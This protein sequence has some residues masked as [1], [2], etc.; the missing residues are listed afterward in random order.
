M[1][2][3]NKLKILPLVGMA[4]LLTGCWDNVE[5]NERHVIL[6]LAID[7][8]LSFNEKM[9]INKQKA[10]KLTYCIPDMKKLSGQESLGDEVKSNITIEAAS[11]AASIDEIE[12]KTQDTVTFSHTKALILGEEILKDR[13]LFQ[14]TI[15]TLTRDMAIS[16]NTMI[17]ATHGEAGEL[18]K[19][20]NPQNP[21]VGMYVMKYFNNRERPVSYAKGQ[22]LGSVIKELNDTSITTLPLIVKNQEDTLQIKGG[23]LIKDYELV[24]WLDQEVMRGQLFIEGKIKGVPLVVD[25][26]GD[27]LTYTIKDEKSKISFDNKGGEWKARIKLTSVGDISE[28]F[29]LNKDAA[30]SSERIEEVKQLLERE[31]KNEVLKAIATSKTLNV[32]FLNIG[33]EMYRKHPNQWKEYQSNWQTTGYKNFP[34]EIEPTIIIQNTG[35]IQ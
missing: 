31:V 10:Y 22:F 14:G 7:K 1:S 11:I 23:A 21:L 17:L 6:E 26:K 4:F 20:D 15:E 30:L 9:P 8:N 32:D 29:T 12:T 27:N 3:L 35:A 18:T 5:L 25:Y 19:G 13:K 16:R 33:L 24:G 34:I 28:Y 2:K